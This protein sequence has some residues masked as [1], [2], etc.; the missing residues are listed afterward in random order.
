M[1]WSL[2]KLTGQIGQYSKKRRMRQRCERRRRR[3]PESELDSDEEAGAKAEP[4]T[5]R[6]EQSEGNAKKQK[7][8]KEIILP[9]QINE[10][11][12][13]EPYER[14]EVGKSGSDVL[15]FPEYVLK[16]QAS[17]AQVANEYNMITWLKGKIPVPEIAA[18]CKQG[19]RPIP[20]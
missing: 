11:V 20:L 16:T 19:D 10:I 3:P 12:G 6:P 14:N 18:Y 2:I 8:E 17:S 15:I 1:K 13:N 7:M 5:Q 9:K 4:G